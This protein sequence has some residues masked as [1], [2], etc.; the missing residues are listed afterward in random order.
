MILNWFLAFSPLLVILILMTIFRW[1]ASRAGPAGWLV[2]VAFALARFGANIELLALSQVKAFLLTLDVL[3][4]IW[5]AFLLFKVV[6]EAGAIQTLSSAMGYLT[7]NRIMQALLIG[8]VFATFLQGVGGFGVPVAVTAPLLIGLG[9]PPVEAVL[10]PSLGHAWSVTF[11]SLASSFQALI[12]TTGIPG[13]ILAPASAALLGIGG[14]LGGLMVAHVQGGWRALL[15]SFWTVL[16]LGLGMGCVQFWLATHGMWNLA[17]F[18][19]GLVGLVIGYLIARMTH[20]PDGQDGQAAIDRREVFLSLVG[21][22]ILVLITLMIFLIRPLGALLSRLVLSVDFPEIQT[23]LGYVTPAGLG[24]EIPL[25]RH[26]GAILFYSSVL[27]FL[28]YKKAGLY[29][30][31]AGGRIVQDTL[32]RVI[33][34]SLGII[35]LVSMAVIMLH[36]GMTE[37][38]AIGLANAS[39]DYFPIIS[40]WIGALG[41]FMTGSNTNSNVIFSSLQLRTADLLGYGAALILAA[42]TT[43]GAIGSVLAPTKIIVGAGPVGLEG[44]EGAILRR[45][46]GYIA[47]LLIFIGAVVW[48]FV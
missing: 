10:I 8:W 20:S 28:I 17:G 4:I 40:P 7:S 9:F 3:L 23:S 14:F 35:S 46:L 6:D 11:G 25:L 41:A 42:Q 15:R 13:E 19:A 34:S 12:A 33:A 39:G 31:G 27:T 26:A 43:G 38:L 1:G 32:R 21:Y 44:E 37:I 5:S 2:A 18:G 47:V 45:M 16:V 48:V 36:A 30:D 29:S 24:R 22:L